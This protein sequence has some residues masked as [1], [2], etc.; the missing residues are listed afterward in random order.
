MWAHPQVLHAHREQTHA[1]KSS[2]T[3]E[4]EISRDKYKSCPLSVG[5][6]LSE[7]DITFSIACDST[8]LHLAS[9]LHFKIRYKITYEKMKSCVKR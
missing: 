7:Y 2:S 8:D 1:L 3:A 4:P 5:C 9:F 6:C